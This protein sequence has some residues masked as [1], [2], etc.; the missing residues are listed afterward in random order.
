M[1]VDIGYSFILTLSLLNC[2]A[3]NYAKTVFF[4]CLFFVVVVFVL[5]SKSL[6]FVLVAT[7][8]HKSTI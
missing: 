2:S 8:L 1:R 6:S 3:M 5:L 7:P 4:V